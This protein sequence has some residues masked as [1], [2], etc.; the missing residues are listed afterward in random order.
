MK[1]LVLVSLFVSSQVFAGITPVIEKGEVKITYP[2]ETLNKIPKKKETKETI[3]F[4]EKEKNA[5]SKA[6]FIIRKRVGEEESDFTIKFRGEL[7]LNA[8]LYQQLNDSKNGKLK[9]EFDITYNPSYPKVV[10]SCSFKSDGEYLLEEHLNFITM[11]GAPMPAFDHTLRGLREYQVSATSW[12]IKLNDEE[13]ANNPF[14]KKPSVEKWVFGNECVLEVSGKFDDVRQAQ[15]GL[16]FLK[17][18]IK[19]APSAVQGNKTARVLGSQEE[20]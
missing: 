20:F 9:C 15:A 18:L 5:F 3:S 10:K 4:F 11:V 1:K 17:D 6:G 16:A 2:C 13:K 12:K 8:H 19:A 7:N 14:T